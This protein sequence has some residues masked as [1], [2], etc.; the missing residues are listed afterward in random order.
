VV[1]TIDVAEMG[2]WNNVA[3]TF[4]PGAPNPNAVRITLSVAPQGLIME[5]LGV[6]PPVVH[7]TAIGAPVINPGPITQAAIVY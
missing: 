7:A 3:R 5:I 4:T 6:G 1:P 2:V